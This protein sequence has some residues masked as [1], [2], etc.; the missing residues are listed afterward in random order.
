VVAEGLRGEIR[1]LAEGFT[2]IDRVESTLRDEIVRS[3]DSLATLIRLAYTDLDRRVRVLERHP[4]ES[5]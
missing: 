3:H 4:P 5:A 2:R 1:L